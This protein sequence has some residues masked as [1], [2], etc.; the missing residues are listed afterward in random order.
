M[1]TIFP[2]TSHS[3]AIDDLNDLRMMGKLYVK[4]RP[5]LMQSKFFGKMNVIEYNFKIM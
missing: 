4:Q 3:I 5:S 2:Q 1:A